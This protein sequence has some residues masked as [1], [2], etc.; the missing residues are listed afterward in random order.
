[1]I[2]YHPPSSE[3]KLTLQNFEVIRPLYT[4][5]GLTLHNP[6]CSQRS[7]LCLRCDS[8]NQQR[9]FRYHIQRPL[10]LI[11]VRSV[12]SEA[13]TQSLQKTYISVSVHKVMNVN[14]GHGNL[15][16]SFL[17]VSSIHALFL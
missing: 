14:L 13:P 6:T 10:F 5:Q 16:F 3:N 7:V 1:M 12:L 17:N 2:H 9:L 15:I 11:S 4:Q 8:Y